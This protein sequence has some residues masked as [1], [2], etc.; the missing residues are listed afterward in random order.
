MLFLCRSS[1]Y[2][3]QH[4]ITND[5]LDSGCYNAGF[6]NISIMDI[7]NLIQSKIK[8]NIEIKESND[9][10]S[11][12]QDSSKLLK[13]GF[14]PKKSVSIA[15]DEIIESYNSGQLSDKKQWHTVK[16]MK[17]NNIK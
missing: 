17:E 3:Y 11:Y 7:A 8:C 10:R 9:P 16:W 2:N 1:S 15:I 12:R 13:T 4:F 14:I 6:E 5:E